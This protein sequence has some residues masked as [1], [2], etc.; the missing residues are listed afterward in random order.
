MGVALT[1]QLENT[2]GQYRRRFVSFFTKTQPGVN[3]VSCLMTLHSWIKLENNYSASAYPEFL[4]RSWCKIFL[5]DFLE[6]GDQGDLLDAKIKADRLTGLRCYPLELMLSGLCSRPDMSEEVIPTCARL[7]ALIGLQFSDEPEDARKHIDE[8]NGHWPN[9]NENLSWIVPETPVESF[10]F[11]RWTA[12]RPRIRIKASSL[13]EEKVATKVPFETLLAACRSKSQRLALEKIASI[14][15]AVE[16]HRGTAA[17]FELRR[18]MLLIGPSGSGKSWIASK[19][20][21]K[22]LGLQSYETTVAAWSVR[23]AKS[24]HWTIPKI[25]QVLDNGPAVIAI[26]ECDKIRS[27]PTE[28]SGN[29]YR[30]CQDEIMGLAT[31]SLN[32][33]NITPTQLANLKK[34]WIVFGGAFQ[35]LYAKHIT[36]PND[37]NQI[38]TLSLT[39]QE[40]EAEG[41][42]PTELLNRMGEMI[43]IAPPSLSEIRSAMLTVEIDVGISVPEKYREEAATR[44]VL[45]RKGFRGIE[46]YAMRCARY[47]TL[48]K[49]R[50]KKNSRGGGGTRNP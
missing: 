11:Y 19:V 45:S 13:A 21:P 30:G 7:I 43:E 22:L 9:L 48:V 26:D 40:V 6:Q 47:S 28:S 27:N 29:W 33:F 14:A 31:G 34:S 42:L 5:R 44:V 15:E 1:T 36:D 49:K 16:D 4:L 46:D 8:L 12:V 23:N 50:D 18:A 20:L 39:Y 25:L 17:G 2:F 24:D 41:W 3:G 38:E 32:D 35:D 10:S 37:V